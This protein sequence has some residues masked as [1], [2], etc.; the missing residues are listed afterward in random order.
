[1]RH[2]GKVVAA[3][4]VLVLGAARAHGQAAEGWVGQRVVTQFGALLKVGRQVVEDPGRGTRPGGAV[5]DVFRIYRVERASGRWLWLVAENEGVRGWAPVTQVVPYERAIAYFTTAI[6]ANSRDRSAYIRR[7]N[8]WQ[9]KEEYDKAIADFSAA[10]RLDPRDAQA[11][12]ARSDARQDKEDYDKAIADANA[13]IRLDPR[14]ASGYN[15]RGNSWFWKRDYDKAIADQ[16]A[17]IRLD[18]KHAIAYNDRGHAWIV[19]GGLRQG[20]RR[21][22]RGDPTRSQGRRAYNDRGDAWY[23]K[24]D[25]DKAIADYDMAIRLDPAP[26]GYTNRGTAWQIEGGVRQGHQ[27]LR[28]GDPARSQG[29]QAYN[30]RGEA[31]YVK[32]E[33]DKAIADYDEAIRLD[34]EYAE[35]YLNRGILASDGEYDKAI[36]DFNEAIRLDPE[37]ALSHF[38]PAVLAI[39]G[40]SRQG[41]RR[42]RHRA[43]TR[44]RSPRGVSQPGRG[45]AR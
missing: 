5:R 29:R 15:E 18:P 45:V 43:A 13:A 32:E 35:A 31:W 2:S 17:A 19:E 20:H 42:F 9:E 41:H 1:M 38:L 4:V 22:Q 16:T 10:I 40:R 14:D 8:L 11:Y 25:L 33:L 27:R 7:G 23:M 36:A 26:A 3:L 44:A 24:D 28:R 21:F 12:L 34:P 39:Q 30:Y 6:R 37:D